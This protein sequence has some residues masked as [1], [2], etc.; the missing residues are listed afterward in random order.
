MW[1][2]SYKYKSIYTVQL[3]HSKIHPHISQ[4]C[5]LTLCTQT[6]AFSLEAKQPGHE[7]HHSPLSCAKAKYALNYISNPQMSYGIVVNYA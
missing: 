5:Q 1:N 7:A 4:Y 2:K 3:K 6:W